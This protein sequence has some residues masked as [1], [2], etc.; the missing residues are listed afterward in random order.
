MDLKEKDSTRGILSCINGEWFYIIYILCISIKCTASMVPGSK[1]N[2][3]ARGTYFPLE[4]RDTAGN[5]WI[6]SLERRNIFCVTFNTKPDFFMKHT[7]LE[8]FG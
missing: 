7:L 8:M 5:K 4:L 1:S 2:N 3:T 6:I